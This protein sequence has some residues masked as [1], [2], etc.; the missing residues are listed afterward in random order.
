LAAAQRVLIVSE[1]PY[2]GHATLRRNVEQLLDEGIAVDL[3]CLAD[4]RLSEPIARPRLEVHQMHMQH[5][6]SGALRYLIE[7]FGFFAWSLPITI[8]LSLRR[9]YAAVLV[10]NL[11]DFLV[12]AA[13]VA[14]WRGAR[15]VLEMFELTPELTAARLQLKENHPMLWWTRWI[16]HVATGWADHVIVVSKQCM[17]I[18]TERGVDARRMSVLPN[19]LPAAIGDAA[20]PAAAEAPFIVTHAT[21]VERYGVQIAI[22]ALDLLRRDWPELTLRVLGDGEYKH[23]LVELT[24]QLRLEDRVV[25][26]NFVPW[27]A[28]MAE[29]R[30]ASVGIVAIVADGYGELLLPTKL[31]EYVQHDVPVVCSR[32]PTIANHFP[33]DA[34]AY[35]DP[36]DAAG[37]AAQADRLLRNRREAER[38]A[39]R[40]KLAMRGFSWDA[41]APRYMAALGLA[42]GLAG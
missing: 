23:S 21:L 31:L 8:R 25:F 40:A 11:P 15:V 7:Y 14:R 22:R 4:P 17:D 38:Q 35:F 24:R 5:R 42:A 10:D 36:G 29:I 27:P 6:R 37:L 41:L 18:L 33:D 26:R 12:F 30:Q 9:R 34:V 2:P 16:E 32:L 28:A 13:F 19:A 1:H 39:A 3:V 20:R